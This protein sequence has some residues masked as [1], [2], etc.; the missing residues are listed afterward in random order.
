MKLYTRSK[1]IIAGL[2]DLYRY[3][4]YKIM[5][6]LHIL[7]VTRFQD[8]IKVIAFAYVL[9]YKHRGLLGSLSRLLGFSR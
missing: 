9:A 4:D 2:R 1:R 8:I 6:T 5:G 3:P 7:I